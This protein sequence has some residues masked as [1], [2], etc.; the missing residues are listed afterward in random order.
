M[1]WVGTR[2]LR[3]WVGLLSVAAVTAAVGAP[4]GAVAAAAHRPVRPGIDCSPATGVARD[5]RTPGWHEMYGVAAITGDDALSVGTGGDDL[6]VRSRH[7]DGR[8]W[9]SVHAPGGKLTEMWSV[10]AISSS[11]VW[12][13]GD[14]YNRSFAEHW[15]GTSWTQVATPPVDPDTEGDYLRSVDGIA[16]DDVWAVGDTVQSSCT[17]YQP[18]IEHWDGTSWSKVPYSLPYDNTEGN[19]E[20]VTVVSAT[21]AWAVGATRGDVRA[22]L[23][24]HWN[25]KVWKPVTDLDGVTCCGLMSVDAVSATDVWAVGAGSSIPGSLLLHWDGKAWTSF[26]AHTGHRDRT[27][28]AVWG[29]SATAADD[30]W[31]VGG[32][33]NWQSI[34]THVRVLHWDGIRWHDVP[35]PNPGRVADRLW[36][37]SGT[38]PD[39]V[40]A[41]GSFADNDDDMHSLYL[42]WDGT[43]WTRV[44]P[45]AEHR[46]F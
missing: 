2:Q 22:L 5:G 34:P 15:D 24:L 17:T 13:V 21:D 25:G 12:G 30:V 11:D 29:V 38:G 44:R 28:D 32:F 18:L 36:A 23:V 14:Q 16:A 3:A 37:V 35:A 45:Q 10:A 7:W 27:I 33:S 42:H 6:S 8:R 19:L 31:A 9:R 43:S 4:A 41:V 26:P 46:D 20:G 1:S 39:D 40:W